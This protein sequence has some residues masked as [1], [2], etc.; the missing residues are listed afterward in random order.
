MFMQ[1]RI[2][3]SAVIT[4]DFKMEETSYSAGVR[5]IVSLFIIMLGGH[6]FW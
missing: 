3:F 2:V 4:L 5:P 6:W 1:N